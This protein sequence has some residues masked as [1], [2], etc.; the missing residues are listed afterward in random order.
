[1]FFLL[2]SLAVAAF[3]ISSPI[4]L[5]CFCVESDTRTIFIFVR[6]LEGELGNCRWSTV[7]YPE[8]VPQHKVCVIFT[9]R[10]AVV[11]C[12]GVCF[13]SHPTLPERDLWISCLYVSITG[14]LFQSAFNFLFLFCFQ[15]FLVNIVSNL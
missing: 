10:N 14:R 13:Q 4:E 9:K 11:C 8:L 15:L 12:F 3:K 6:H 1:M 2:K 5:G 7:Q